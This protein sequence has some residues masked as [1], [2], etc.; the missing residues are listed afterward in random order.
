LKISESFIDNL[1]IDYCM[2]LRGWIVGSAV[3]I[4]T[5]FVLGVGCLL[6]ASGGGVVF[7]A[8]AAF[9][10]GAAAARRFGAPTPLNEAI[11]GTCIVGALSLYVSIVE[12]MPPPP[13]TSRGGP[14]IAPPK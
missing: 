8:L 10:A 12:S 3:A 14:N 9:A 2:R 11:V 6:F 1:E 5:L 7:A 13:G 4:G